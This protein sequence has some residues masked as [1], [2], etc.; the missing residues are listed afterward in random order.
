M[1][2]QIIRD[3]GKGE[4][5]T[6]LVTVLLVAVTLV[7]KGLGLVSDSLVDSL[8][9]AMLGFLGLGFLIIR[10]R[11]AEL[12]QTSKLIDT[13]NAVQLLDEF[14][15]LL[16][17]YL[18]NASEILML[19]ISLRKTTYN[20]YDDFMDK[21]KNGLKI[22]ALVINPHG[23]YINMEAVAKSYSRN[24]PHQVF[25]SEY[26]AILERYK[27]IRDEANQPSNIQVGLLDFVP[28]FSAYIFPQ[29][30]KGGIIFVQIYAYKAPVGHTPYFVV[31]QRQNPLW[32]ERISDLYEKMWE[33]AIDFF[34]DPDIEY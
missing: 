23:R 6:V 30:G 5:I 2:K 25:A 33:D 32:Y 20:H 10:Y 16:D 19:G 28:P 15:P 17:E 14:P 4:N 7:A 22:R 27:L 24:D 18:K 12:L 9:L 26:D 21:V 11:I 29:K 31:T 34:P 8:T 13:A 1:F 3:I